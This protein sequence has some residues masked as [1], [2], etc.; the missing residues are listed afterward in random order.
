VKLNR[1]ALV[2]LI[3]FAALSLSGPAYGQKVEITSAKIYLKEAP[4]NLDKAKE[5]LEV[6]LVK[7]PGNNEGLFFLG[8]VNYYKGNFDGFFANWEKVDYDKLGGQEKKQYIQQVN[9]VIRLRM[10]DATKQY[11]DKNFEKAVTQFKVSISAINL[12]QKSLK[13][14]NKKQDVEA[15]N[16]L[17]A[18]KQQA[19][20]FMG[21][22][23]LSSDNVDEARMALE[24]VTE[25]D[26]NKFEAWDGLVNVYARQKDYSKLITACD[27]T[28]SLNKEPQLNTFLLLRNAYFETGDTAK[29]MATY[30]RA[31]STFPTE[32]RLYLDLGSMYAQREMYDKAL[33]A[34]EKGAKNVPDNLDILN[35]QGTLYYNLGF[36]REQAGDMNGA[37]EAFNSAM[38]V[39]EKILTMEPKSIDANDTLSK[40]YFGLAKTETDAAKK[41]AFNA[42][43]DEYIAKKQELIRSGEG[44]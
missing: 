2:T 23:A 34:L 3:G 10:N 9:D 19:Y 28:I 26:P 44:K 13:G 38:P 17:E 5:L 35:F 43:G 40:I 24:K 16:Q 41:Q 11:N 6:A 29:V 27:K 18:N 21:Y 36:I 25:A 30:E 32:G 14:S 39:L 7:D 1:F 42:K 8:M 15:S 33:V 4:P 12:M 20:L 31:I 22:S 37:R